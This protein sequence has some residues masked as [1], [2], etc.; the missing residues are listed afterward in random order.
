MSEMVSVNFKL[1]ADT[2]KR[3]EKVCSELGLSMTAAFTIFAKTVTRERRIPFDLTLNPAPF[4]SESNIRYLEKKM[5][6]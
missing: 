1:D 2:K 4:Y 3:M 5:Q 6:D